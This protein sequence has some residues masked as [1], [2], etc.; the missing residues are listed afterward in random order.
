MVTSGSFSLSPSNVVMDKTNL[1]SS[2][3]RVF[4]FFL[5]ELKSVVKPNA[6]EHPVARM[7]PMQIKHLLSENMLDLP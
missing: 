7:Q 5:Y 4:E 6:K 1:F 3:D 2:T